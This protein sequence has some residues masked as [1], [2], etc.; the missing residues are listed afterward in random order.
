MDSRAAQYLVTL[1]VSQ[2]LLFRALCDPALDRARAT[3]LARQALRVDPTGR[4]QS[5]PAN[6]RMPVR[7]S[8]RRWRQLWPSVFWKIL[9]EISDGTANPAV[10]D[11]HPAQRQP[12]LRSKA[13]LMIGRSGRSLT[14]I[15]KRV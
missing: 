2:N 11:A 1:L 4:H 5:L 8:G 7:R 13:V 15:E 6:W 3:A 9:D 12:F 10:A 14:W